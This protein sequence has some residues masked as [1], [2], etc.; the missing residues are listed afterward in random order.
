VFLSGS[1]GS[2]VDTTITI[3]YPFITKGAVPIHVYNDFGVTQ[4]PIGPC[5]TQIGDVTKDFGISTLSGTTSPSGAATIL[6]DA[7][8]PKAL[9]SK[10][11]VHVTGTMPSTGYAYVT[12]HL[13]YGLRKTD[14]WTKSGENAL[15]IPLT[16]TILE[17][18]DYTFT[19][20]GSTWI[21]QSMNEFK[22]PAGWFGAVNSLTTYNPKPGVTVEFWT[23]DGKTK[24]G[25][26]ITDADGY[27][28]YTYK[29]TGKAATYLVKIPAL[30]LTK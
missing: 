22:K 5:F 3:P 2:A 18:Q 21:A 8:N 30:K 7:Y 16:V 26:A 28:L 25:S 10:T 11:T 27:Y 6:L 1:P 17:P 15:N 23:G 13:E 4:T 12:I 24:I 20:P 9:G 14:S 29:H 19:Y